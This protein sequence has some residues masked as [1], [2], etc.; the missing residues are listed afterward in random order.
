VRQFQR[1]VEIH[2]RLNHPNIIRMYAYFHDQDSCE[3]TALVCVCV[4]VCPSLSLLRGCPHH[5][6]AP[7]CL[8]WP[9]SPSSLPSLCQATW[10]WSW[11]SWARCTAA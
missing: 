5:F 11:Q 1:E 4:C 7:L 9:L 6:S 3:S 10:C 2:C 8:S